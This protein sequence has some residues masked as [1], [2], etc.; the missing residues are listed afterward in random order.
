MRKTVHNLSVTTSTPV[1]P[2]AWRG[3]VRVGPLA[4]IPQ[5]LREA[6]VDPLPV[7]AGCGLAPATFDDAD[8]RIDFNSASQLIDDCARL[9]G[10]P[11]F[12]L[13]IA[14]RFEL[15]SFGI[16]A[17]LMQHAPSV[18]AALSYLQHYFHLHDRGAV[19][20]L[21]DPGNGSVA[22]GYTPAHHDTPGAAMVIDLALSIGLHLMRRI[23]GAGW[24]PRL[25]AFAHA[26]PQR[27]APY[28]QCFSA[29]VR[30]DA[31]HSELQFDATWLAAPI[32][33]ADAARL[34]A[35]WRAAERLD[36][37]R[38]R[39]LAERTHATAQAFV[40]AGPVSAARIA[41]SLALHER[42]L[43]R[44]LN[45]EGTKLASIVADVRF[46]VAGL[47]LHQ[48]RLPIADIA[49]ALHYA[50]ATAFSRAFKAFTGLAPGRW[51]AQSEGSVALQPRSS[52]SPRTRRSTKAG[53]RA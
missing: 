30:F 47:L 51:R 6:G 28:R 12:G 10:R 45:A 38:E 4:S 31:T 22:L 42:T 5:L 17:L 53:R 33:G 15:E 20:H 23:C 26:A 14:Q 50:D 19:V 21:R 44:R 9:T 35:L 32:A 11:D 13:L 1:A 16:V 29:P 18:G 8:N 41:A 36:G 7:L 34:A 52:R 39:S 37:G 48:T 2:V 49:A 25:V 3:D 27:E 40:L 24:R 46:E 43:R